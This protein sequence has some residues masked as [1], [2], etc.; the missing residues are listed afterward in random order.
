[1]SRLD[2]TTTTASGASSQLALAVRLAD[3]ATFA[4]FYPRQEL[5]GLLAYLDQDPVDRLVF[6]H[7]PRESG[8]SHL[9][10]ALC[11]RG[12]HSVYLPLSLVRSAPAEELLQ[13]LEAN[14]IVAIDELEQV[15]GDTAWEEGLFHLMNRIAASNC[16]LAIGSR[17]PP[18]ALPVALAD[19]RSRLAA[20]IVWAL[21]G[22]SQE[23]KIAILRLRA[24]ALGLLMPSSVAAYIVNRE[25][26]S[27]GELLAVLEH[28]DLASL[29]RQRPLTKPFVRDVLGWAS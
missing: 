26:R 2:A 19:L 8:K 12:P 29:A 23:E 16:V 10:Q 9:L 24:E 17:L 1:M 21:P 6:L 28:L 15:A 11:H 3:D 14:Q 13:N 7:G 27:L 4:N 20:G 22:C 25:G 18:N 5:K